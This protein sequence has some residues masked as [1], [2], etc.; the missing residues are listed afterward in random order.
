M[1]KLFGELLT[2]F[3]ENNSS[4][5]CS[6]VMLGKSSSL[7]T[8]L[9]MCRNKSWLNKCT[10]PGRQQK[11]SLLWLLV[12]ILATSVSVFYLDLETQIQVIRHC[13]GIPQSELSYMYCFLVI[14][15]QW[16]FVL[17]AVKIFEWHYNLADSISIQKYSR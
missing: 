3:L 9:Y 5:I 14:K 16:L 15:G 4:S 8:H 6:R 17:V 2:E 10:V 12:L 1:Q 11:V 13:L 7:Y